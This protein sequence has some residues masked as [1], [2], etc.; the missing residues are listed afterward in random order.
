MPVEF[1]ILS[2]ARAGQTQRFENQAVI[3]VGRHQQSDLRFD[4]KGD[5]DVSGKHAELRGVDGTYTLHDH[6]STNGT[7]VNGKKVVGSVAVSDG[8]VITFG[9]K[10]PQVEFRAWGDGP[11]APRISK[12]STEARI[13]LAVEKQTKGMKRYLIAAAGFVVVGVA[14]AFY[15]GNSASRTRIEELQKQI[16]ASDSLRILLQG[17]LRSSGDTTLA[18][19]LQLKGDSLRIAESTAQTQQEKDSIK[20]I[21]A[22]LDEQMRAVIRY[23]FPTIFKRNSPGVAVMIIKYKDGTSALGTGFSL[24]KD[25]WVVTNAHNMRKVDNG[26]MADSIA[27]K[28]ADTKLWLPAKLVKVAPPDD[29]DIALIKMERADEYPVVSG[30]AAAPADASEGHSV[31][32]IGFPAG[33]DLAQE[34]DQAKATLTPG[35]VSKR[36]TTILQ[37]DSFAAHGASGSPVFSASGLV[38]GVVYGGPQG[39]GGKIVY[40][41]PSDKLAAFLPDSLRSRFVR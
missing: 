21:R 8:D 13:A 36:T 15:V 1:K 9:A 12:R 37:M 14:A 32:A 16:A 20:A 3:V 23:D 7:Y 40:A 39:T 34:G 24:S 25:G 31:V 29:I 22:A 27:V 10:G 4:P 28:F 19:R 11:D 30:I 26:S 2:G 18:A 17:Q 6:G 5:L 38:V 35:T 33:F 41:V